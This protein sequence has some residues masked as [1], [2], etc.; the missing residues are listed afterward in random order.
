M[1]GNRVTPYRPDQRC[2]VCNAVVYGPDGAPLEHEA[3]RAEILKAGGLL[4]T[5]KGAFRASTQFRAWER[6]W[7]PD[8]A[9]EAE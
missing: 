4:R 8:H 7:C 1:K 9:G 5:P 2:A 6:V 3:T